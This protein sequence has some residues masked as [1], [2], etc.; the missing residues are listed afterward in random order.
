M[1]QTTLSKF[2]KGSPIPI[3]T[4]L[5]IAGPN[6][7]VGFIRMISSDA[8]LARV[9]GISLYE[10]SNRREATQICAMISA[11]VKLRLNPC[12]PVE[13]KLQSSAQPTCEETHN[14][15]RFTSGINTV[16][17]ELPSFRRNSHLCVPSLEIF[18]EIMCGE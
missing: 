2:N 10:I 4:T 15:P 7:A 16:S 18:S 5:V 13:Q 1:A 17:M 11:T 9:Y 6:A 3:K 8:A 14:V 12:L